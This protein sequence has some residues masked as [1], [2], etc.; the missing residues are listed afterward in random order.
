MPVRDSSAHLF[1]TWGL[2]M[3]DRRLLARIASALTIG[4]MLV[5]APP[6]AQA[7]D[8]SKYPDLKGQWRRTEPGD[9]TRFDPSK[10][11]GLGQ[12]APLTPEYQARFEA[13]LKDLAA[14]GPGLDPSVTCIPPG[15]PRIMNVYSPMEIVVTP[16]TTYILID[17]IYD[18]RRI[19][20][21]GREWPAEIEPSYQGYS[22]G[23]WIDEDGDGKYDV[24]VVETRG[25]KGP[26][27]LETTGLPLH[28]DNQ[29][30][31]KERIYFDKSE[32]G[33]LHDEITVIDN[34]FTRPWTIT[35]NYRRAGGARP[36]WREHVCAEHNQ[37][38]R[39]G[40]DTYFLSADG[41]LM[42]TKKDQPPPDLK[43]FQ[44]SAK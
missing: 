36:V 35:K 21:D 16:D 3:H 9:P 13:G 7:W 6:D 20:T 38:M 12:Q 4:L 14:G 26:R 37:H 32:P 30:I 8:D 5:L 29:T 40:S 31:V 25:F 41:H 24:L 23:R 42:P 15:M 28:D 10:P 18:N 33:I 43:Y 39:I 44:R 27:A 17:H 2:I 34:A 22:I 11:A 1:A 19:Y